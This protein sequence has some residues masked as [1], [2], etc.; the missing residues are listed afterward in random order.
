MGTD[1]CTEVLISCSSAVL[2]HTIVTVHLCYYVMFLNKFYAPVFFIRAI[3]G[4]HKYV[5]TIFSLPKLV[6]NLGFHEQDYLNIIDF[7]V[8]KYRNFRNVPNLLELFSNWV[9]R[10]ERRTTAKN[11]ALDAFCSNPHSFFMKKLSKKYLSGARVRLFRN[12]QFWRC[13]RPY[14]E[15]RLSLPHPLVVT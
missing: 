5:A 10:V 12:F 14:I 11:E 8:P 15:V 9:L 13:A 1:F 6:N 7:S 4:A 3:L 2:E